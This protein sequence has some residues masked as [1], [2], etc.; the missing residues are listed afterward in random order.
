MKVLSRTNFWNNYNI[1]FLDVQKPD[2]NIYFT[3]GDFWSLNQP[4]PLPPS[5]PDQDP[6]DEDLLPI[7]EE[8]QLLDSH[9]GRQLFKCLPY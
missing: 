1:R 6:V 7:E 9:H 3:P 8:R 5:V 2:N 4:A